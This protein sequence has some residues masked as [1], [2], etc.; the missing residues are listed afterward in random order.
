MSLRTS[1][2]LRWGRALHPTCPSEPL[3]TLSYHRLRSGLRRSPLYLDLSWAD[4]SII[5]WEEPEFKQR[6]R[7]K[8]VAGPVGFEP[9]TYSFPR[10]RI[11]GTTPYGLPR[12]PCFA[13]KD[14]RYEPI[15]LPSSN[16]T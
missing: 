13:P 16:S 7:H 10:Q 8:N 2:Y 3:R 14:L 6:F 1:H 12:Y 11:E 5:F 4:P 9:T 15:G